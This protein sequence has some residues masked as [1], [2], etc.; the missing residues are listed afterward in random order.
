VIR[1]KRSDA[2]DKIFAFKPTE[3]MFESG[4]DLY[5]TV[6]GESQF[7]SVQVTFKNGTKSSVQKVV[8]E[9]STER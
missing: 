8:R 3:K 1:R 9:K 6:P 4:D 7:A 5:L 2:L